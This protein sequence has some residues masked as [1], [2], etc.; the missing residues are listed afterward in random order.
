VLVT[1]RI[2]YVDNDGAST[3]DAAY[4][5]DAMASEDPA[6]RFAEMLRLTTSGFAL[7]DPLYGVMRRELTLLPRRNI[8]REDEVF[9]ARLALA[10]PWGHVPAV[11]AQRQRSEVT[12]RGLVTLLGVPPW[13][14][15]VVDLLQ[16]RD[17]LAWIDSSTLDPGQRRRL[18]AEARRMY[19]RRKKNKVRRGI[20][21]VPR[22]IGALTPVTAGTS[23]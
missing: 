5:P 2:S 13:H 16:W 15:H 10:G 23:R 9:A 7:L 11:L 1:T 6:E 12:S 22:L 19:M 3:S 8:L 21:K 17:L 18:H 20:Q 4:W 14:R